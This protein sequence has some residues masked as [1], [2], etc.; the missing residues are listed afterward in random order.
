MW[1]KTLGLSHKLA[2]TMALLLF[3][4]HSMNAIFPPPPYHSQSEAASSVISINLRVWQQM[5]RM[6]QSQSV[7]TFSHYVSFGT[8]SLSNHSRRDFIISFILFASFT[9]RVA[10]RQRRRFGR[11]H[12]L[13][14]IATIN[15]LNVNSQT[16]IS[17]RTQN[18]RYV[19]IHVNTPMA[20]KT[21]QCTATAN[22]MC[23]CS[24]KE[25]KSEGKNADTLWVR[26][27]WCPIL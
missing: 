7:Y 6:L 19:R 21:A 1:T 13:M 20:R 12:V 15:R 17:H 24:K 10:R 5:A 27:L 14:E 2:T 8:L 3:Q 25:N 11:R 22:C 16:P 26:I 9:F 4:I 18:P 23:L